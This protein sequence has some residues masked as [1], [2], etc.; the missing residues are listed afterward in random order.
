MQIKIFW[1][2]VACISSSLTTETRQFKGWRATCT[3]CRRCGFIISCG[4]IHL[5]DKTHRAARYAVR[6]SH[7]CRD[8]LLWA[9]N[10]SL[11][12]HSVALFVLPS[13]AQSRRPHTQLLWRRF[14]YPFSFPDLH[15][16][17][18]DIEGL[19][20]RLFLLVSA[21]EK[22]KPFCGCCVVRD[23]DRFITSLLILNC[24]SSTTLYVFSINLCLCKRFL[25]AALC[26]LCFDS[27]ARNQRR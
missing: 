20:L 21:L 22:M 6:E 12:W 25:P 4:K 13:T 24:D 1:M 10:K 14:L 9:Q 8:N 15:K 2:K 3:H 5:H 7:F 18:W 19:V 26:C 11:S 17:L 27:P 23:S 16:Y